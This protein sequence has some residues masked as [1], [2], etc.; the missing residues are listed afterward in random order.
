MTSPSDGAI[1]SRFRIRRR[2]WR[3]AWGFEHYRRGSSGW[4]RT[5]NPPVNSCVGTI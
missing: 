5:S 3:G 2:E 1:D 4:T